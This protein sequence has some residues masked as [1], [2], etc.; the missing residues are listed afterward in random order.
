MVIKRVKAYDRS[1]LSYL[2]EFLIGNCPNYEDLDKSIFNDC[3]NSIFV[4]LDKDIDNIIGIIGCRLLSIDEAELDG[5]SYYCMKKKHLYKIEFFHHNVNNPVSMYL[6][7]K[8]CLADKN[9]GFVV[10][11]HRCELMN[12]TKEIIEVLKKF[13]FEKICN[14]ILDSKSI[15]LRAPLTKI[16]RVRVN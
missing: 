1:T 11:K 6:L 15:W 14:D 3:C 12:N 7:L 16:N 8:E 13:N 4:T 2:Y 9:D 5:L 10:Y